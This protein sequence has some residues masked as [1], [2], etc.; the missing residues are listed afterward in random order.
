MVIP[1]VVAKLNIFVKEFNDAQTKLNKLGIILTKNYA[2]DITRYLCKEIYDMEL[3]DRREDYDG[4]IDNSKIKLYFNSCP[5][6]HPVKFGELGCFDEAIVVLGPNSKLRPE[7]ISDDF[8]FYRFT[9]N[10]IAAKFRA[11]SGQ[12]IGKKDAFASPHDKALNLS[13]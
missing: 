8:I 3:A 7:N 11:P 9:V 10:E 2:H 4:M 6:G 12:Y 1:T 13:D 5:I